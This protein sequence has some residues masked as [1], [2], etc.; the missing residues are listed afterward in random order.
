MSSLL[1]IVI[2]LLISILLGWIKY[3]SLAD[4]Y[5]NSSWQLKFI[6]IWNDFINFFFAGLIGYYFIL[7]KWPLLLKGNAL[8]TSDIFLLIILL[9]GLF[10]HLCVISKNITDGIKAILKK[11]LEVT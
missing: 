4:N 11:V 5:K 6:E 8:N 2:I 9:L 7:V 1:D 3:G 10:G